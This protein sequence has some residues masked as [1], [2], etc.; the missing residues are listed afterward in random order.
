MSLLGVGAITAV[1]A[2]LTIG[3]ELIPES[4]RLESL[5]QWS[6][7]VLLGGLLLAMMVYVVEK[8]YALRRVAQKLLEEQVVAEALRMRLSELSHF[9]ELAKAMNAT[10]ELEDVFEKILDAALEL[11]GGDGASVTLLDDIASGLRVVASRGP[12]LENSKGTLLPLDSGM[13]GVAASRREAV[14]FG[15]ED[16][17]EERVHSAM[18]IP[19]LR[20]DELLGVLNIVETAGSKTFDPQDLHV[21]DL[22][23]EYAAIAL[24]NARVVAKER[25]TIAK[26]E[27]LDQLKSDFVATVSHELRTPLTSIIGSARTLTRTGDRLSAEDRQEFLTAIDRQ[28][29]RLQRLIEDILTSSTMDSGTFKLRREEIDLKK[30]TRDLIEDM[31]TSPFAGERKVELVATERPTRVWGDPRGIQQI[32]GN[33]IENA[34][35]YSDTHSPVYVQIH[36]SPTEATISITDEGDGIPPADIPYIFDRFHRADSSSTSKVGGSGIGLSIV[37]G[38]VDASGGRITVESE[39]GKGTTFTVRL[40]QRSSRDDDV[41]RPQD[42]FISSNP[43]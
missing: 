6:V 22:F 31:V 26:L 12:S 7:L 36:T 34:C 20:R 32:L 2:L 40:P 43:V 28:G 35:K 21:L 13:A 29:I 25:D 37:K 11:L 5:S 33:L 27:E 9:T 39:L 1:I 24:T 15:P 19:L 10:L 14:L 16:G 3:K 18:S 23:G 30:L 17:V 42:G 8:E 41:F 38:L 4:F